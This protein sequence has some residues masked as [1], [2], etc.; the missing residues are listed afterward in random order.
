MKITVFGCGYVGLTTAVG[1][2]ELG[3]DVIGI[4]ND[5]KKV[6]VLIKG[7]VPFFEPKLAGLLQKNLR[8]KLS[9]STDAKSAIEK[10]DIIFSAV[11]TPPKK[12]YGADLSAVLKVA[13]LFG[14]YCR[15]GKIFINKSTVPVGTS[16]QIRAAIEKYCRKECVFHVISNPEF[17]REGTAINDFFSPDRIIA[18]LEKSDR[19]TTGMLIKLI[20]SLYGPVIKSGAE[21]LFTDIRSSECIKYASNAYLSTRISFINELANF[22]EKAGADI[23]TVA[24]GVGL[25]KR[26]GGV[27]LNAGIGF[28]GSCLPKDLNALINLGNSKKFD[29]RLLKAV[30]HI[31][32]TQPLRV[33]EKLRSAMKSL[34]G[35]K[36][37]V[38]GL[39]FKPDTDDMRHAPSIAVINK[40]LQSGAKV[41]AYDP[42][43][44]PN[45]R[46]I[47]GNKVKFSGNA[48]SA[49]ADSDALLLLTEWKEFAKPDFAKMKSMMRN[50]YIIDG[51]NLLSPLVAQKNGFK[52]MSIGRP[53]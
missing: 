19:K 1:L 23:E 46:V 22:C 15:N 35:K 36:I 50:H 25:D 2:A 28:G 52:Y 8:K 30:R 42:E 6:N 32:E 41:T 17:L 51:R 21:I 49:L 38:W 29:F 39:A 20:T 45:A 33:M 11:G 43:A 26:I 24:K 27:F 48:Y 47:F 14:K 40:L 12:D 10:S 37:A 44:V 53:V 13:A 4:D 16:E 7:D 5:P 31:N 3:H 34:K 18:G 9:F